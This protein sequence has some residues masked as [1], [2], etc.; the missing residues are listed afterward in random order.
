MGTLRILDGRHGDLETPWA[1]GDATALQTAETRFDEMVKKGY[2]A[3]DV[4]PGTNQ[5]EQIR[6][7]NPEAKEIVLVPQMRG[8]C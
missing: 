5:G 7:F 3:F 6:R 8:G 1:R 4:E 2:L